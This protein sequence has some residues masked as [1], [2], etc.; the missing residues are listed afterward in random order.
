MSASFD[1]YKLFYYVGK[2]KNITHA[3]SALFI[4]QSTVSRTIQ[5]LESELGCKLF[6]RTQHGVVFTIEGEVLYNHISKACEQIF[7]GEEKVLEMQQLAQGSI[8][9]GASDFTF[10]QFVLPVLKDFSADFPSVQVEMSSVGLNSSGAA[11]A[12]LAAGRID[13]ACS[14]MNLPENAGGAVEAVT[15]AEYSDMVIASDKFS[16]LRNG[17]FYLSDLVEY[18]F[19]SLSSDPVNMSYLDK[20]FLS[21]GLSVTPRYKVDSS[22]MFIPIVRSCQCIAIVPTLF[23]SALL[24][25]DFMAGDQVFEVS[26]REPLPTHTISI[27]TSKAS[28]QSAARDEFVKQLKKY[29]KTRV[30]SIQKK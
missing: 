9:L 13:I 22:S 21:H 24:R 18:P 3:A 14:A 17:S 10:R 7:I 19:A 15:V 12:A 16:E 11:L 29:I 25:S 1:S 27:L 28:P 5:S 6:D 30:D 20:L 4:S 26:M 2:Y 23:R 8:R